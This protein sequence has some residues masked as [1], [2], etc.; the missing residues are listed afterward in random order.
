MSV[1]AYKIE[2]SG[3]ELYIGTFDNGADAMSA[4]NQEVDA[5]VAVKFIASEKGSD[6]RRT[7]VDQWIAR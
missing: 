7:I 2:K 5:G 6:G 4:A 3:L 1:E